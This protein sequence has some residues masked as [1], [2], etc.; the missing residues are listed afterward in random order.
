MKRFGWLVIASSAL[1]MSCAVTPDDDGTGSDSFGAQAVPNAAEGVRWMRDT[2]TEAASGVS[3]GV[4][5]AVQNLGYEKHVGVHYSV[6]GGPWRDVEGRYVARGVGTTE[7]WRVE[8][9]PGRTWTAVEYAVFYRDP[10]SGRVFWDNNRGANFRVERE[11]PVHRADDALSGNTFT[12][13][14]D[15]K[16]L[17][18]QKACQATVTGDGWMSTSNAMGAYVGPAARAGYERW[19]FTLDG[20]VYGSSFVSRAAVIEYALSCTFGN[21]ESTHADNNRGQNYRW[22][23][24]PA[25]VERWRAEFRN[26]VDVAAAPDGRVFVV[27]SDGGSARRWITGYAAD[28]RFAF[29]REL[30]ADVLSVAYSAATAGPLAKLSAATGT[31]WVALDADGRTRWD[32][33]ADLP[34]M[35]TRASGEYLLGRAGAARLGTARPS[36][37]GPAT[38]CDETPVLSA[39]GTLYCSGASN[40]V[41]FRVPTRAAGRTFPVGVPWGVAD[42]GTVLIMGADRR[43]LTGYSSAARR[44]WQKTSIYVAWDSQYGYGRACTNHVANGFAVVL[45]QDPAGPSSSSAAI[46]IDARTG[47]ERFRVADQ[48]YASNPCPEADGHFYTQQSYQ[49]YGRSIERYRRDGAFESV[50]LG[51]SGMLMGVLA[52]GR[53]V[54][55]E[56]PYYPADRARI[57]VTRSDLTESFSQ[58]IEG[59]PTSGALLA[60]LSGPRLVVYA[61]GAVTQYGF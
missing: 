52:D 50:N 12:I 48:R 20:A 13:D 17:A 61:R 18:Y 3:V 57:V 30:D 34:I 10:S 45:H 24:G 21:G 31:R 14:V 35:V 28:G 23:R 54:R 6:D 55:R 58:T 36:V 5:V 26:G 37:V 38:G 59:A 33:T 47:V 60:A 40:V 32:L 4:E 2:L 7:A 56:W 44:L 42:D 27:S 43:T 41:S 22:S 39:D 25:P 16:N 49:R 51:F 11:A 8:L 53:I 1:S 15:V 19:R 46:G 9:T 29:T